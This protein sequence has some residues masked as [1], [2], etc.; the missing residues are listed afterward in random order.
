MT[1]LL[2]NYCGLNIIPYVLFLILFLLQPYTIP[3][4]LAHVLKP[5]TWHQKH[6][7]PWKVIRKLKGSSLLCETRKREREKR[8]A[9]TFSPV[10]RKVR[11]LLP[12]CCNGGLHTGWYTERCMVALSLLKGS[13]GSRYDNNNNNGSL[14]VAAR[15][16]LMVNFARYNRV[17]VCGLWSP[18]SHWLVVSC[19]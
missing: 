13:G 14:W 12:G 7:S 16:D 5:N 11:W 4:I 18:L 19:F 2:T 17:E 9:I 15:N 6:L 8:E 1:W 3:F 10:S